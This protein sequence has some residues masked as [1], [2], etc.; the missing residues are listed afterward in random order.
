MMIRGWGGVKI[1]IYVLFFV[2]IVIYRVKGYIIV[3][4]SCFKVLEVV[5]R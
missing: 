4:F 2:V 5:R 3:S 1:Y